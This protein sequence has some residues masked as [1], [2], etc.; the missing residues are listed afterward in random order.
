MKRTLKI[1]I[2]PV[3][4]TRKS[5]L[6]SNSKGQ[7]SLAHMQVLH[8]LF[9]WFSHSFFLYITDNTI[10]NCLNLKYAFNFHYNGFILLADVAWNTY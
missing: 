7:R 1:R 5:D 9:K 4:L 3:N 10:Q 6:G 8:K 2:K